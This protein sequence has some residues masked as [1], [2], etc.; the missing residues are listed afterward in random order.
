MGGDM[1]VV[2]NKVKVQSDVKNVKEKVTMRLLCVE[3]L[4]TSCTHGLN[5]EL[6]SK[7]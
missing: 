1:L 7:F 4:E 6:H 5:P 2:E 3:F